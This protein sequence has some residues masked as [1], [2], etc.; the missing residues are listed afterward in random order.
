MHKANVIYNI[1]IL[2][3][4]GNVAYMHIKL[5]KCEIWSF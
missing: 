2:M 1:Y 3:A 4:Y 5:T